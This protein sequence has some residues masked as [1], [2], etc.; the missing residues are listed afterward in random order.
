ME[1]IRQHHV[2]KVS[3]WD[4]IFFTM[5]ASTLS[6]FDMG[7]AKYYFMNNF[8]T[9]SDAVNLCRYIL[10]ALIYF[11]ISISHFIKK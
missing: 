1:F 11:W 6:V 7:A 9:F 2:K 4:L 5:L 3:V 10:P 8:L